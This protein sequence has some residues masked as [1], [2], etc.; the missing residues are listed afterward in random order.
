VFYKFFVHCFTNESLKKA[1]Y[2]SIVLFLFI[3]LFKYTH[4]QY[5]VFGIG[6]QDC[7]VLLTH[8]ND[9]EFKFLTISWV[10][11]FLSGVNL[12]V[13]VLNK[14]LGNKISEEEL[15]LAIVDN[16]K[17]NPLSNLTTVSQNIFIDINNVTIGKDSIFFE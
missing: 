15:W 16:C 3:F 4:A 9:E 6:T 8:S 11:G 13:S 17:K 12:G 1:R 5:R 2:I 10:Q 7:E 14:T